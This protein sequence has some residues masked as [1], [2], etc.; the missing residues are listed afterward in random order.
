MPHARF[1]FASLDDECVVYDAQ[2]GDT[3]ALTPLDKAVLDFLETQPAASTGAIQNALA[4]SFE[5][6]PDFPLAAEL[7]AALARLRAWGFLAADI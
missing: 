2:S 6:P 4:E 1:R 7:N 5:I 3:H